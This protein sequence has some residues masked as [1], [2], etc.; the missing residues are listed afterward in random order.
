M[1]QI[2]HLTFIAITVIGSVGMVL[3]FGNIGAPVTT[4]SAPAAY[5]EMD[6][7]G[8]VPPTPEDAMSRSVYVNA[9]EI[10]YT[11]REKTQMKEYGF[12]VNPD[13]AIET[14]IELYA[15]ARFVNEGLPSGLATLMLRTESGTGRR[16]VSRQNCK[17][18]YQF[19]PSTQKAYGLKDPFNLVEST[20][21]VIQLALDNRRSLGI[22]NLDASSYHLYLSHMIGPRNF[23]TVKLVTLGKKV[24]EK[25][26]KKAH[27]ALSYNWTMRTL[28]KRTG[29]SAH[30]YPRF[31]KAFRDKTE[32]VL[33]D[34]FVY[35]SPCWDV[36]KCV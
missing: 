28:G 20:T 23:K 5:V 4:S 24:D 6:Q 25:F 26:L 27:K 16:M 21:A 33:Q 29:N 2:A 10:E 18:Y 32:A 11:E 15:E 9:A 22:Y 17:G 35:P 34:G 7:R 8:N 1:Y 31:Y 36:R 14:Q 30:D 13:V 12:I 3:K 19:C